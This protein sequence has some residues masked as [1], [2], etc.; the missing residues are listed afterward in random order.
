M[1]GLHLPGAGQRGRAPSALTAGRRSTSSRRPG[2]SSPRAARAGARAAHPRDRRRRPVRPARRHADAARDAGAPT[3]RAAH[4][5]R[6]LRAR[7]R[8]RAR[9]AGRRL[10]RARPASLP[11]AQDRHD[12]RGRGGRRA[13]TT[14]WPSA[15][16]PAQPRPG[17][18]R[19]VRPR[20]D[21]T[22]ASPSRP[23][24][25]A[26]AQLERLDAHARRAPRAGRRPTAADLRR[27]PA[28]RVA[29]PGAARRPPCT[30]SRRSP[31]VLP[32]GR[33][34]RRGD[35]RAGRAR[36]SRA[37][38]PPTRCTASARWPGAAGATAAALPVADAC[39]TAPWRCRSRRHA[40][41]RGRPGRRRRWPR[42]CPVSADHGRR[43]RRSPS[44]SSTQGVPPGPAPQAGPR[45]RRRQLLGRA[46]RDLRLPRPQRRRQD[47]HD[48]HAD[49]A[50]PRRPAAAPRIFGQPVPEPR[51]P[52]AARLPARGALLLRLPDRRASC[53]TWSAG[54]SASTPRDAP[55]ARR[56]AARARRA[57]RA[58]RDRP[59]RKYS[60]GMLQRAGLAQALMNDPELVVLD[61]PMSGLDPIGRK[62][63]RD[64]IVALR[65]ARQ[66]GVLLDPHPARRRGICDRV[67]IIAGGQ[68]HDVGPVAR[69]ARRRACSAPTWSC[70]VAPTRAARGARSAERR[71]ARR[72]VA[73]SRD[74]GRA[75]RRRRR[76]PARRACRAR[77]VV[78]VDAAHA[79]RSRTSSCADASA[80]RAAPTAR[81]ARDRPHLRH[82]AQHLP[83]GDP[84]Q[85]AVRHP[86]RRR[87]ALNL[88]ALV[89]GEMS[90]HEEARVARDV[91]LGGVSL[92]GAITAIVLGV[93]LLYGEIQRK[94]IHT[95]LSKPIAAPRVRARQVP[96][97]GWRPCAARRDLR[98][99]AGLRRSS[100]QDVPFD[101]PHRQGG[102]ARPTSRSR[103]S[104]RSRCSSRRSRRPFLSGIFTFAHLLPRPRGR[105]R[106]RR[107][108]AELQATRSSCG[109][110]AGGAARGARPAPVLGL[111]QR[112]RRQARHASTA[113][114]S[115]GATSATAAGVR[116]RSGSRSC[117]RP[118]DG[119][120]SAGGTSCEPVAQGGG[121]GA[122]SSLALPGRG[123]HARVWDGPR[124]AR[125]D[126]AL[127]RR[128]RRE[129]IR[130][131]RRAAR[132]YRPGRRTSR[133]PT[134][135]S[136]SWRAGRGRRRPRHGAGGL[137]G[138]RSSILATR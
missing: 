86:G 14:S 98:V 31:C 58:P 71:H 4:R 40:P 60:K 41:R 12:R 69:A 137:A 20:R 79:S 55:Q 62:E 94:T 30:P 105:P 80:R 68:V 8:R 59:L 82:R 33:R 22:P 29:L 74:R 87:S 97:H 99:R 132:W 64:L 125:G 127:A 70:E 63:V 19:A 43:R 67:A 95:I 116:R 101:R 17:A 78:A 130:W 57:R 93:S 135:G 134:S 89:L 73:R 51:R 28:G 83:R 114:S 96:R 18:A 126:A 115:A 39:T 118:R 50:H 24:R 77:E 48:P 103:W 121:R 13:T 25:S 46:R 81:S 102:G 128:R 85:G 56:R 133:R 15:A 104:R 84:Q 110:V 108:A 131:W 9:P 117:S 32:P 44:R 16:P 109:V 27:S 36:R 53:S 107:A 34:P 11:P 37:A 119:S 2:T 100:L 26:R 72:R 35:R 138:V 6:G 88:F 106:C 3:R 123:R 75:R 7:R 112:G 42:R 21:S 120:S 129:A 65:D 113:T 111:G 38:R 122:C 45:G 47:H 5:G 49:G 92:F 124:S 52:R 1:P 91:G 10:R 54:C 66:D 76:L 23:P 61:E 136:R 90:L